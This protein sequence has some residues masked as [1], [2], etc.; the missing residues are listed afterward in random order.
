MLKT[1]ADFAASLGL[2]LPSGAQEKLAAYADLVWQKK[3]FLNLTSVANKDEIFTRHLCDGL[4]FAAFCASH[5]AENAAFTVADMGSGAGYIGLTAAIA[6]PQG[7][8]TLVE[9]LE[10]RCSFL[11]WVILKLGLKNVDVKCLRLGEKPVGPFD[12]VTERAMG[13]LENVLPLMAPT[14]KESG[15]LTAYQSAP[16]GAQTEAAALGF[17]PL[18]A[19]EYVLPG[20]DKKRYLAVF[21][22][23]QD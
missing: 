19:Q 3:D 15:Y 7:R 13:Q 22:Q 23:E 14:V 2:I 11:N 5:T 21:Q 16:G 4:V 8:V 6:L 10:K 18:P 12:F 17:A 9:S 20:E 1:T